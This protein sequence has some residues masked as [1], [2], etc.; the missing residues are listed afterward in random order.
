MRL[1]LSIRG[2]FHT[3]EWTS[4]TSTIQCVRVCYAAS[5][6]L[7]LTE[8]ALTLVLRCSLMSKP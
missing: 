8:K 7:E 6:Q 2:I 4:S 3:P 5:L 1:F